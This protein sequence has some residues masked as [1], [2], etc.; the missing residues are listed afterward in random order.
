M[1][2][3][4]IILKRA[5]GQGGFG[6][7][8]L[9]EVQDDQGF[10]KQIAIKQLNPHLATSQV[11]LARQLAE[12]RL[13]GLLNHE[14]IVRVY[15]LGFL[16]GK[17]S[18]CLEYIEG[19]SLSQLLQTCSIPLKAILEIIGS[20]AD[21]LDVAY[22][23]QHLNSRERLEVIHRDIKPANILVS[24]TGITKLLDF[25]I[26][27]GNFDRGMIISNQ[28]IG[29]KRY[30]A[31]EQ[32]LHNQVSPKVDIYA[33]GFTFLE[34][35][36]QR[37]LPRLA[38]DEERFQEER[39][40]LIDDLSF[41]SIIQDDL[42]A[43]LHHMLSFSP[44][45][46]PSAL[47]VRRLCFQLVESLS[48]QTLRLFAQETIPPLFLDRVS[49]LSDIPVPEKAMRFTQ[50]QPIPKDLAPPRIPPP[51]LPHLRMYQATL[52]LLFLTITLLVFY[53]AF[54]TPVPIDIEQEAHFE[55]ETSLTVV[56]TR[57]DPPTP[58]P[59]QEDTVMM[60]AKPRAR[61]QVIPMDKSIPTAK[62]NLYFET[63][64]SSIPLGAE[65]FVDE[66][67]MGKTMLLGARIESGKHKIRMI[68]GERSIE[69]EILLQHPTRFVW[70]S[71]EKGDEQWL[72][73]LD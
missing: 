50:L 8:Y 55:P 16:D 52:A 64:F 35:L 69:K 28:Q 43:L 18:V 62:K 42:K 29:T 13:L 3:Q 11:V 9:A 45:T 19:V 46:R 15:D 22:N 25:G 27:K 10:R 6:T 31:P 51:H 23:T 54:S 21:A 71:T 72:S 56:A 37:L 61:Q 24:K 65:I 26:A 1:L 57:P 47:V 4:K 36:H 68:L 44:E 60:P 30:M 58:F 53:S 67:Y 33:L 48:G 20:C 73:F 2:H 34:L 12:A 66:K 17:L 14:H 5:I 38:L 70:K 41:P 39:R 32:W 49:S 40:R 7:V 63:S 59:S